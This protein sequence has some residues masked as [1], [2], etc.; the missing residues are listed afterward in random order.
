MWAEAGERPGDGGSP[1]GARARRGCGQVES[2]S[3]L[4]PAGLG[5][6]GCVSSPRP[7]PEATRWPLLGPPFLW[8]CGAGLNSAPHSP[9]VSGMRLGKFVESP[10]GTKMQ[11]LGL[12]GWREVAPRFQALT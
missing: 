2:R 10:G 8:S 4:I 1:A 6:T 11:P 9:V 12:R 7:D 5:R 3:Q